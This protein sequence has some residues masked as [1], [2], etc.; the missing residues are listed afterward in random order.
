MSDPTE[1]LEAVLRMPRPQDAYKGL[2]IEVQ[3]VLIEVQEALAIEM[4]ECTE[5][6][7]GLDPT[8]REYLSVMHI[9]ASALEQYRKVSGAEG[10]EEQASTLSKALIKVEASLEKERRARK[11]QTSQERQNVLSGLISGSNPAELAEHINQQ[12]AVNAERGVKSSKDSPLM[13]LARKHAKG[14]A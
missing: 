12:D 5:A 14:D 11:E 1:E 7:K 6:L 3:N 2:E 13:A 8:S 9:R 10:A 4:K